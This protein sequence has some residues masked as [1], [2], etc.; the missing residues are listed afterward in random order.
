M[1][2]GTV[3]RLWRW[4]VKSMAGEELRALSLGPRG[5]GGDRSHAVLHEHKGAWR[6]LTA[7]EA[8]RLLA[9]R[10][11]YPFNLDAGLDP[12]SPPHAIVTEPDGV[13]SW[14]WG[15]P[16]LRSALERDLG[17]P[18]RLE[19]DVT[20]IPD[21]PG[22]VLV[23]VA[24]SLAALSAELGT[25]VDAR[26]FRTNLHLELDADPWAEPA[27][28]GAEIELEGGVR[29]RIDHAC[30]RCAIP[31]RDPDTQEKWPQLLRHLTAEHG[32]DFGLL[33]RV[34]VP[35]RVYAGESVRI[36]TP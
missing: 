31:T 35:G 5:V 6:P 18:V 4:P 34:R 21:V 15:D 33:A 24:G 17:R 23:T 16:R 8:P 14:R 2:T 30:E 19:R 27:W 20:G 1:A 11:A 9:W 32:Q 10:A 28:A 25:D 22:T 36:V 7:R 12:A 3:S 13:R 26:R 29:L